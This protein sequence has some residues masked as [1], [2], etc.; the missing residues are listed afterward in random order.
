M[1]LID[2]AKELTIDDSRRHA[3]CGH[4]GWTGIASETN[5]IANL[6]QRIYPGEIVP[7]GECPKC[8]CL[9]CFDEL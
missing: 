1:I 3:C 2:L 5:P 4:C 9:A 7:I 6:D 8:T